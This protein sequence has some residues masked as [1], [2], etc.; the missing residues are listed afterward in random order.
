MGKEQ[1]SR[2]NDQGLRIKPPT[3]ERKWSMAKLGRKF[4]E[5]MRKKLDVELLGVAS[6]EKS[7]SAEL[8]RRAT[9]LLPG[10]KSVV[11]MAKEVFKE[12]MPLLKPGKE[13]GEAEGGEF[14]G[15]HCDYLNARLTKGVYDLAGVLHAKGYRVF[16][17]PAAGAPVDQRRLITLFSYKHAAELAG[18]GTMGRHTLL[19]T[20]EYGPRVRLAGLLT[21]AVIEPSRV[22]R[23]NSCVNCDACIRACPAGALQAPPQGRAYSINPFAC[24]TYRGAGLTCNVCLKAC[25]D[26]LE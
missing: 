26:V 11:I 6:V 14:F 12:L 25:V 10:A 2:I 1:G 21:D 13:A 5:E 18:L 7:N 9:A 3:L 23:K 20:P 4:V 24:R 15:P 16:P 17:L 22:S 8:K 19:I